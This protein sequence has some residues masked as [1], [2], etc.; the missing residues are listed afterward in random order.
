MGMDLQN[1]LAYLGGAAR[2]GTLIR[3][4]VPAHRIT[5][6]LADGRLRKMRHGVVALPG[7][8]PLVER[9]ARSG[10]LL[11]C[12]SAARGAGLRVL[13][14]PGAPHLWFSTG[15]H[16]TSG[17]VA[18]RGALAGPRTDLTV[19]TLD[20]VLAALHCQPPLSALVICESA[21]RLG[22]VGQ[23]ELLRLLPG[24][25]NAPAAEVVRAVRMDADSPLEIIAQELFRRAGL[26]VQT[27][28]RI[29][30]VGRVDL[31]IEGFLIV[32]LDGIQFHW[33]KET[34]VM[35]RR[36]GNVATCSG[37]PTLRYLHDDV[38]YRQDKVLAEVTGLLRS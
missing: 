10:G 4:G 29:P 17:I 34:F 6:A 8:D 5:T 23:E 9:A 3:A 18:H 32:E 35:D 11:T 37:L 25:R 26:H 36:R 21:V 38:V 20:T 22:Q 31:L 2:V 14:S 24:N 30:G 19:S 7:I 1:Y 33:T 28:V 15:A 13:R 27:Q 16:R 12:V